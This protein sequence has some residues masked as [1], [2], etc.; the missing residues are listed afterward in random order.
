MRT[1][2][3]IS[4]SGSLKYLRKAADMRMRCGGVDR[5]GPIANADMVSG[6]CLLMTCAVSDH[7]NIYFPTRAIS[8][9]ILAC[10]MPICSVP[11]H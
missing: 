3:L 9:P 7:L 1:V 6:L 4:L 5:L 11:I 8:F 10:I 2:V